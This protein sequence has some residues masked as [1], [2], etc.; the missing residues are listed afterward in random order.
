MKEVLH[1]RKQGIPLE[2]LTDDGNEHSNAEPD[3]DVEWTRLY[4]D[5][6]AGNFRAVTK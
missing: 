6:D 4:Y 1:M 2:I 5:I 3:A